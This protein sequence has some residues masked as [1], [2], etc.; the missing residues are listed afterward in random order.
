MVLVPAAGGPKSERNVSFARRG[1]EPTNFEHLRETKDLPAA[2]QPI[3]RKLLQ[4]CVFGALNQHNGTFVRGFANL[5]IGREQ[6]RQEKKV[7][8][9]SVT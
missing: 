5:R 9:V 2:I 3:P 4:I 6:Q 7:T 8:L 1:A